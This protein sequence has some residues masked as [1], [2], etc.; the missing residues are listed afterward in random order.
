MKRKTIQIF[1][2]CTAMLMVL[3]GCGSDNSSQSSTSSASTTSPSKSA[4][5][6]TTS[7]NLQ[8]TFK[9][10][11]FGT[12]TLFKVETT[13]KIES[14]FGGI[15]YSNSNDS[16]IFVDVVI[17]FVYEGTSSINLSDVGKI[18][19]TNSSGTNYTQ[20]RLYLESSD[21]IS[22]SGSI[23]PL[24]SSRIHCVV[25]VPTT[26]TNLT[27]TLN[28]DDSLFSID[29]TM[30]EI[31]SNRQSISVGEVIEIDDFATLTFNGISYTDNLLPED[32]SGGY[33]HVK[34]D[35]P[36]NT[37]IVVQY[38][39]TNLQTTGK[40]VDTFVAIEAKYLDKYKY[41]GF[42]K[43]AKADGKG[44]SS[45]SNIDPLNTSSCYYLIEVPKTVIDNPLELTITFGKNEYSFV[46]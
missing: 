10:P 38:D 37:Y 11:D 43:E 35:D 21:K 7:L 27:L 8:D 28:I 40:R 3:T 45:N 33:T 29:Y 26:E 46:G 15:Y 24:S 1:S 18:I 42:V 36:N 9:V 16:E 4:Q 13:E 19:A 2:L 32:T 22:Q 34:C 6:T 17:D 41:S 23:T 25:V 31:I 5:S 39:L 12:F 20:N 30:Q 14:P 44:F